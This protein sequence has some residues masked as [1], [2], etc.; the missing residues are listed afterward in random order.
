MI[1]LTPHAAYVHGLVE[2]SGL[3]IVSVRHVTPSP[4]SAIPMASEIRFRIEV[5]GAVE[6]GRLDEEDTIGRM[7][8]LGMEPRRT[9]EHPDGYWWY[10]APR[11]R[12]DVWD[13]IVVSTKME[14]DPVTWADRV[15]RMPENRWGPNNG[16]VQAACQEWVGYDWWRIPPEYAWIQTVA[17]AA[18]R[19]I[20][21][22]TP[23]AARTAVVDEHIR[24]AYRVRG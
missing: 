3:T 7:L 19:P 23:Q 13:T 8:G 4:A 22:Q 1:E 11:S 2:R 18:L 17:R 20:A 5:H 6:S 12:F 16:E 15:R 24:T 14:N 21:A 10:I 9:A